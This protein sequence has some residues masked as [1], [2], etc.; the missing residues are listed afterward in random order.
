MESAAPVTFRKYLADFV[1]HDRR[2]VS[3]AIALTLLGAITESFG[4]LLLVPLI[5]AAGVVDGSKS[6]LTDWVANVLDTI[7]IPFTLGWMLAIYIV[8]VAVRAAVG[9]ARAVAVAKLQHQFVDGLRLRLF[10]A[11]ARANWSFHLEQR[12]SDLSHVVTNDVSRVQSGTFMVLDLL[13]RVVATVGYLLVAFRLS[14]PTTLL[15]LVLLGAI[16]AVLW[17]TVGRSRRLGALQTRFGRRSFGEQNDFLEALKLAKSHGNEDKHVEAYG[18]SVLELRASVV[19]HQR[20]MARSSA[21]MTTSIAATVGVLVWVAVTRLDTGGPELLAL[22]AVISRLAPMASTGLSRSQQ[23]SNMLPA[24]GNALAL[25]AASHEAAEQRVDNEAPSAPFRSAIELDDVSFSYNTDREVLAGMSLRIEPG[26]TVALI[27]PSGAGKTTV[28]DVILG[29]LEPASGRVLVDGQPLADFGLGAWRRQIAYVPQ[30]TFLFHDTLRANILWARHD[31]VSDADLQ[32]FVE[33][34]A[35]T[36]VVERLPNGLDTMMGDRG[37]R[38]SG[39]ER[40]RVA[41]ARALAREPSL[42]VLDEA[43]SALD[44]SNERSVQEAINNLHGSVAMLVIAHRLSTVRDA[45][46]IIMVE[47]GRV[48]DRGTWGELVER[49]AVEPGLT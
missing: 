28:G 17:P 19:D 42:L 2:G 18:Q 1:S 23:V 25:L 13:G 5:V 27:G 32:A 30:E 3:I 43:T 37:H 29:L 34:A 4:L 44:D 38:L 21:I 16:V 6:S 7:G 15:A 45:D 36:D 11:I 8:L 33:A 20:V 9:W 26:S 46:E 40:Q 31:D 24:Y 48:V 12:N 10:D 39:G 35:L 49:G 41:L 22:I 14:A 47:Q